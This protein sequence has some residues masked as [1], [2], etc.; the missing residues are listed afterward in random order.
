MGVR[1][2]RG[3]EGVRSPN[4]CARGICS[5]TGPECFQNNE[6]LSEEP[7]FKDWPRRARMPLSEKIQQINREI[8]AT[9]ERVISDLRQ[10]VS[11]RLRA[12]HDEILQRLD[13]ISPQLPSSFV[14]EDLGHEADEL[15]RVSAQEAADQAARQAA[16]Q[17]EETAAQRV[18]G[19]R[20][21]AFAAVR[22]GLAGIDRARSQVEILAALL[23]EAGRFASRAAVVLVRGSELRGWGGQ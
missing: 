8:G 12:G 7:C 10:E 11:Q 22:D 1:W 3:I 5:L 2:E 4:P 15:A 13:E 23:R 17:A 20:G 16:Q 6:L 9:V 21:A 14:P 18:A 19:A